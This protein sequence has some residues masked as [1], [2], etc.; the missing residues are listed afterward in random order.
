MG[1][2]LASHRGPPPPPVRPASLPVASSLLGHGSLPTFCP[3]PFPQL[4]PLRGFSYRQRLPP[5]LASA[6]GGEAPGHLQ[7]I[8]TPFSD[9]GT[10]TSPPCFQLLN[11]VQILLL[12]ALQ[13]PDISAVPTPASQFMAFPAHPASWQC[14]LLSQSPWGHIGYP[15]T[16]IFLFRGL[17]WC[18][19]PQGS[20]HDHSTSPTAPRSCSGSTGRSEPRAQGYPSTP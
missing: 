3:L 12:M 11:N 10:I 20:P 17:F 6:W 16:K 15:E 4:S 8:T 14:L 13:L 5:P 9:L 19:L 2:S 1:V 18:S 7:P